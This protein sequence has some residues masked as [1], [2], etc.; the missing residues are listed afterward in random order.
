MSEEILWY[1]IE[2]NKHDNS[3]N[4]FQVCYLKAGQPYSVP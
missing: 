2:A 1:E 3:I 4:V